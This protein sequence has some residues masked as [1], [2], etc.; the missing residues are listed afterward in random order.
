[1]LAAFGRAFG[2]L[3]E[4]HATPEQERFLDEAIA[5]LARDGQVIPVRLSLFAEMIKGKPWTPATLQKVGGTEGI[6][7]TFLEG[8]FSAATAPPEHR[9]HQRAAR[10]VLKALLPE[11]GTDIKGHLRSQQELLDASGYAR[12]PHEFGELLRILDTELRLITPTEPEGAEEPA[13]GERE[14][15]EDGADD[16]PEAH[17]TGSPATSRYYQLTHDYLVPALRQWLTRKQRETRRGRVQLLL[18][19]RA[20]LWGAKQESRQLPGWWEWL[21]ILTHTRPKDWTLLERRMLLTST[22]RH[23]FQAALLLMLMG[24]VGWAVLYVVRGPL[25]AAEL[26]D[27]LQSADI[28]K[29]NDIIEKLASCKTWAV[30]RLK[31]LADQ[32]PTDSPQ[33]LHVSLALLPW[34]PS[35]KDYLYERL[36]DEK[37][38]VFPTIKEALRPYKQEL[39][40]KLW[41]QIDSEIDPDRWLHAASA[42][43]GYD[44][45]NPRWQELGPRLVNKL[46]TMNARDVDQWQESV[47]LVRTTLQPAILQIL[48]DRRRPDSERLAAAKLLS[49]MSESHA[50]WLERGMWEALL[51]SEGEVHQ[52]L[53]EYI[54][55]MLQPSL[56]VVRNL[57]EKDLQ[58]A[59]SESGMRRH[60]HAAVVALNIDQWK[61]DIW[62]LSWAGDYLWPSLRPSADPRLRGYLIHRLSTVRLN[63]ETLIRQYQAEQDVGAK[64]ALLLCLGAFPQF[65]LPARRPHLLVEELRRLY[66]DN[67]DPGLHAAIDWVLRQGWGLGDDLQRIDRELAGKPQ[68]ARAWYVNGQEQTLVTIRSPVPFSMGSPDDEPDRSEM[69]AQ[70]QRLIPR[71]F[72]V[73]TKEV[74]VGQFQKFLKANPDVSSPLRSR[75]LGEDNQDQ[76]RPVTRVTWL[77]AV[78][79]CRWLSEQERV[80][81]EQ[82]SY[83]SVSEIERCK[84]GKTPLE[85]P[86]NCLTRT[87]YRLPTEAEWEYTCR[88][89]ARTSRHYGV[90]AELLGDY[91]WYQDNSRNRTWPVG[92]KKP[93]DYGLFDMYGNAAEWCQ[94]AQAFYPV[95]P[96]GQ[97]VEDRYDRRPV[98]VAESRVL[99]GGAYFSGAEEVRSAARAGLPP[100]VRVPLAGLRVARTVPLVAD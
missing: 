9:R 53:R 6:G 86:A 28:H 51:D 14:R 62:P 30:P 49:S 3:S 34:E 1:V 5:G 71:S 12:R 54:L 60:A 70:H 4:G 76:D 35:E 2:A 63:P 50:F 88:A 69:E 11:H 85:L 46:V 41:D 17:A 72:A 74:T 26:V 25:R 18:A 79:Y 27:E 66:R 77:E 36:L 19:E 80:S 83:P 67:P 22:R 55:A 38:E 75:V 21:N 98:T 52:E 32:Y 61:G 10:A 87:G 90:A 33:R 47:V 31:E 92:I 48:N 97:P 23:L 16:L 78:Q 57:L 43:A 65:K 15:P 59:T 24:L 64:R 96:G 81:E 100:H 42:L 94:D 20:G 93:N 29:V 89:G 68:E 58:P 95:D 99:R 91:A 44:E 13:S 39:T 56:P 37:P 8:T 45:G 40:G 73:G 84:D 82:M 7:V